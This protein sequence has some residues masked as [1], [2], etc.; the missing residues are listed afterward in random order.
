MVPQLL[1]CVNEVPE[2]CVSVAGLHVEAT[3]LTGHGFVLH[4]TTCVLAPEHGAPPLAGAGLLQYRVSV[5]VPPPQETEHVPVVQLLQPPF[6][7]QSASR[8]Y[9]GLLV[10][11]VLH[12]TAV[13]VGTKTACIV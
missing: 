1:V 3:Q 6:T 13:F 11:N 7:G 9:D 4:A 12:S 5:R 8:T 2:H 10:R